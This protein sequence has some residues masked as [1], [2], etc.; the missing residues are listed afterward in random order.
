MAVLAQRMVGGINVFSLLAIPFFIVAGEIMGHGGIS[1]RLIDLSNLL[2]G[3]VR[4]GLA[5]VN[6]I[7]SMFFGGI[8]GSSIADTSSIGSV[9][10]PMMAKKGYDK[11]YAVAV[12]ISGSTQGILIPP[13]HNMIIYSLAA[14]SSV[15][16]AHM[17]MAGVIPGV[18]LGIALMVNSYIIAVRRNYPRENPVPREQWWPII[19]DASLGL[20]TAVIIMGGVILGV[21][22]ATES[23]AIAVIYALLIASFVYRELPYKKLV[24]VLY[25][26]LRTLSIVVALIAASSAYGW[27]LALLKVPALATQAL[28]GVSSSPIVVLLVVNLLLLFLGMIMDMAPL[29]LIT[30]PILLPVALGIGLDPVHFGIILMLNLAIGLLT[31]PV[32]STL[33]V[34]SAI[35]GISLEQTTKGM[36]PFYVVMFLVLLVVSYFP[37]TFM[38]LPKLVLG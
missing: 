35:G 32:G 19:R 34:G 23:A 27:L 8:S 9:L 20:F 5:I 22:T 37:A 10:I 14:G 18:F 16:V 2:M 1:K 38:W 21:F 31:P 30:T 13:S 28:L 15:S 25:R 11:D 26:C 29:I 17:F 24:H 36:L 12:T 6:V 7:A 3:R 33:F 4:G